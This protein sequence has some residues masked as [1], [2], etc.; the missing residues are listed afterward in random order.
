ERER[1][2]HRVPVDRDGAPVDEVPPLRHLFQRY[3]QRVRVRGRPAHRPDRLGAGVDVGDRDD[4][5][6]RLDRLVEGQ[7][8]RRRRRVQGHACRGD[9][10]DEVGVRRCRRRQRED[11]RGG[12]E[13]WGDSAYAQTS[14]LP[15]LLT[16]AMPP[17]RTPTAPTAS[18][19]IASSEEPPPTELT[20]LIVGAGS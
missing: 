19:T 6:P 4:R 11:D 15:L 13:Q 18:A 1:P 14:C 16:T 2:L 12:G 10:P 17:S 7:R 3:E 8:D 5:E 20:T 9:G